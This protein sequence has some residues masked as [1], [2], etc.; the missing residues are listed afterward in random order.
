M[1]KLLIPIAALIYCLPA[2]NNRHEYEIK[3]NEVYEKSKASIEEVE[4][5][6]PVRFLK[7]SG[8]DKRNLLGQTVIKGNVF[9]NAKMVTYKDIDIKLSFYSKT[10]ALLE[11]D[12]EVVYESVDPGGSAA[13]KSKY[14]APKGTDSVAMKVISAKY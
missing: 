11:E 2:C 3:S 1:K 9:S 6:N 14:F 12:H 13:F 4:K 7:V 5:K 8:N 10:G